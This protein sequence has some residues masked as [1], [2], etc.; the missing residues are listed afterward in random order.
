MSLE[1]L[2]RSDYEGFGKECRS[3]S[4]TEDSKDVSVLGAQSLRRVSF[5]Y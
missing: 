1:R 3:V 4:G 5:R 2:A